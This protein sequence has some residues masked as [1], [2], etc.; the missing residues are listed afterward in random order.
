MALPFDLRALAWSNDNNDSPRARPGHSRNKNAAR[1]SRRILLPPGLISRVQARDVDAFREF[2]QITYFPLVRFAKTIVQSLDE[3]EDI[4]Q[5]VFTL[6]WDRGDHWVP[7]GDPVA[8]LFMSVRNH[9]LNELRRKD[10]AKRREQS[11]Y[12]ENYLSSSTERHQDNL[13]Y[14]IEAESTEVRNTIVAR[15]L[16]TLTERQRSAYDLR[17]RRGLTAAAIGNVLGITTKSA[18]QLISRVTQIVRDRVTQALHGE[19]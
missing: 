18:E 11:L 10:R 3:A 9:A 8:Y 16:L 17:Y 4:V 6:I 1:P 12:S 5:D 7:T 19:N 2:V 15:V 13:D 14:I